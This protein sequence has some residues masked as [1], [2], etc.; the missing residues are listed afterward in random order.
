M[1]GSWIARDS[2]KHPDDLSKGIFENFQDCNRVEVGV[3]SFPFML[4]MMEK[5]KDLYAGVENRKAG[6][7]T[8]GS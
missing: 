4:E 1:E 8:K 2:N 6:K 5:G 3:Q 7:K